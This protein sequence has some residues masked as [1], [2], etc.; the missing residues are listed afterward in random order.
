MDT[1]EDLLH[2]AVAYPL[3][4]CFAKHRNDNSVLRSGKPERA[5]IAFERALETA[6]T[7]LGG[8][9]RLT[10]ARCLF[11]A[12]EARRQARDFGAA[13]ALLEEASALVAAASAGGCAGGRGFAE[14]DSFGVLY[15]NTS[16]IFRGWCFGD[17]ED[18]L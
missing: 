10:L 12:G 8:R 2:R 4:C 7:S 14:Q 6:R 9:P 15:R 17:L 13:R 11:H 5:T 1:Q 16:R 18:N 3:D